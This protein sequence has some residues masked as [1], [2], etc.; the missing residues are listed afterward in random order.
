MAGVHFLH[1]DAEAIPRTV[2]STVCVNAEKDAHLEV[3][4]GDINHPPTLSHYS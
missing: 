4:H 3:L 2:R 1:R